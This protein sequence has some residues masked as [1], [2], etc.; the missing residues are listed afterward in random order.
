MARRRML[1]GVAN[2]LASSFVSR[3][4]DLDG[5]WAIGK[6]HTVASTVSSGVVRFDLLN[7]TADPPT[8]HL[9]PMI[10]AYRAKLLDRCRALGL[11]PSACGA[12]FELGE[13]PSRDF[14]RNGEPQKAFR[15]RLA[16][17]DDRGREWVHVTGGYS[18]PHDPGREQRRV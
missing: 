16:I 5:Y 10:L 8:A 6:I 9:L 18:W 14:K 2:D 1:K 4:N 11:K 15:L 13:G 3:N 12:T 17:R 7:G